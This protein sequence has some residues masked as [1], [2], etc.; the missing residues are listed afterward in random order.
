MITR[1]LI[2]EIMDWD[3]CVERLYDCTVC[4]APNLSKCCVKIVPSVY[5][6]RGFA[7]HL[8]AGCAWVVFYWWNLSECIDWKLWV[9]EIY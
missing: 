9:R 7:R 6:E 2:D 4:L 8:G 3:W 1:D 5:M